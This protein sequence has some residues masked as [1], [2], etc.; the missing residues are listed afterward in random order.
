M[1][2]CP[3]FPEHRPMKREITNKVKIESNA[4]PLAGIKIG[5]ADPS[6]SIL[7]VTATVS[8]QVDMLLEHNRMCKLAISTPNETLNHNPA[9]P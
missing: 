2:N 1:P 6:S 4:I 3:V 9:R 7:H 8:L 5:R